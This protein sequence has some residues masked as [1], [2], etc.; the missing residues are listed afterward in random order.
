MIG[1]GDGTFQDPLLR[2][3][4]TF[5]GS[6]K[7]IT[8][9]DMNNDDVLDII[10]MIT[11]TYDPI[12]SSMAVMLGNGDGTFT[13]PF[14]LSADSNILSKEIF[15]ND[16]D[17]D[18]N[19]DVVLPLDNRGGVLVYKGNGN[20][21]LDPPS[22]PIIGSENIGIA[23]FNLDLLPDIVSVSPFF[24]ITVWLGSPAGG[25]EISGHSIPVFGTE[26]VDAVD[27]NGDSIPDI[28]AM[29]FA[30]QAEVYIGNGDGTFQSPVGISAGPDPGQEVSPAR[31]DFNGDGK[32]DIAINS[33]WDDVI[34][35]IHE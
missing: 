1:N 16:F 6:A 2:V 31:A 21:T 15:T 12:L 10:G 30:N 29:D 9:A 11:E 22:N 3:T 33:G 19:L 13:E 18:G 24:E 4:D 32:P 8:L 20:G 35:L 23:D 25:F 26:T 27:I 17:L 14:K 7:S 5:E 34:I 28:L